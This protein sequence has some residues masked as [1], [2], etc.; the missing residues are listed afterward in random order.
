[1]AGLLDGNSGSRTLRIGLA[2]QWKFRDTSDC[3]FRLRP[4]PGGCGEWFGNQSGA[5][6]HQD[7]MKFQDNAATGFEEQERQGAMDA[8]RHAAG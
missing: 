1:M 4:T 5:L 2:D 3:V 7:G 6:A 8:A